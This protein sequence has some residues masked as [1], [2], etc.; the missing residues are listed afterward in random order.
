MGNNL[1]TIAKDIIDI[2]NSAKGYHFQ[3]GYDSPFSIRFHEI[4][5][6]V[7]DPYIYFHLQTILL[8]YSEKY[9]P[10]DVKEELI[11]EIARVKDPYSIHIRRV[12]IQQCFDLPTYLLKDSALMALSDLDNPLALPTLYAL[13]QQ[14]YVESFKKDIQQVIDQLEDTQKEIDAKKTDK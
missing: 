10:E 13:L 4:M 9:I 1:E 11:R 5:D 8:D 3:A 12:L 6:D 7:A 2:C 14:D